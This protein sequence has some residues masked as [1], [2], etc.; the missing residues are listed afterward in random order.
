MKD[1]PIF[2][3]PPQQSDYV[4]AWAEKSRDR[5]AWFDELSEGPQKVSW[6]RSFVPEPVLRL[7]RILKAGR[8]ATATPNARQFETFDPRHV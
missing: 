2:A 7:R 6:L 8:H 5:L 1:V 4:A 3:E